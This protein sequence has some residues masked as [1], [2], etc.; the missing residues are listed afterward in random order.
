M[1]SK[2]FPAGNGLDPKTWTDTKAGY[3]DDNV[4]GAVTAANNAANSAANAG[5]GILSVQHGEHTLNDGDS[6]ESI[7]ISPV[8]TSKS[9]I[10]VSYMTSNNEGNE[11]LLQYY[12]NANDSLFVRRDRDYNEVDFSWQVVEF[13]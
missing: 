11:Y 9:F 13:E 4:S 10:L 12:F 1:G 6:S 8:D 7:S 2:N 5:K 3:L